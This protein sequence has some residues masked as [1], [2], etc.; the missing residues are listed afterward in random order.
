MSE[1]LDQALERAATVIS[2]LDAA[3]LADDIEPNSYLGT[4]AAAARELCEAQLELVRQLASEVRG[5]FSAARATA[6]TLLEAGRLATDE[7]RPETRKI[8]R[9]IEMAEASIEE[10]LAESAKRMAGLLAQEI[11]GVMV[12]RAKAY[13]REHTARL[14]GIGV[15]VFLAVL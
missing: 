2:R 14:A 4:R 10:K 13:N 15:L 7:V 3:A 8:D 12:M 1:A 6:D 5:Y 11:K 9:C